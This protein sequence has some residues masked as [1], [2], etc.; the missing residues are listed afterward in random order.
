MLNAFEEMIARKAM[1]PQ[2]IRNAEGEYRAHFASFRLLP[3]GALAYL[4]AGGEVLT[5]H[6]AV[7]SGCIDAAAGDLKLDYDPAAMTPAQCQRWVER[8]LDETLHYVK[9]MDAAKLPTPQA[10]SEEL[11]RRLAGAQL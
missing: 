6:P 2:V 11:R 5:C 9:E 10:L 7:K 8:V 4:S 1:K 3:K